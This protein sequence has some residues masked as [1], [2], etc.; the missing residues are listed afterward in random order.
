MAGGVTWDGTFYRDLTRYNASGPLFWSAYLKAGTAPGKKNGYWLNFGS[1]W[2][3]LA[4][5]DPAQM[6]SGAAPRL[7]YDSAATQWKLIVEATM[8]VTNEVVQVWAGVKS[9]GSDPVGVYTRV[10]G[11]DPLASLAVD[12]T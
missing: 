8:F 1:G 11:C 12:G 10:A 4:N 9:G 2:S 7:F 3:H 5:D 6:L